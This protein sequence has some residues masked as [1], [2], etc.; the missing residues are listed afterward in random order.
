MAK[1]VH[2]IDPDTQMPIIVIVWEE[3]D[4]K[5]RREDLKRRWEEED[6]ERIR[7]NAG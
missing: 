6:R 4:E 1:I 3:A 2:D 5:A 7:H